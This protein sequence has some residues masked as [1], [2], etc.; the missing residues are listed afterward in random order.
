MPMPGGESWRDSSHEREIRAM[1]IPTPQDA[2]AKWAQNLAGAT[3]RIQKGVQSVTSS[4]G[5]AAARQKAV[6]LAQVQAK[7][8]K[9]AANTGKVSTA[10]WQQATISK[11]IPRIAQGAQASQPKMEAFMGRFLPHMASVVGSLPPRGGLEANI[12]RMVATVRGAATFK[13]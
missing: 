11:G 5:A 3:D 7:A 2:A 4:P 12:Q 6:Y 9:W 10:D 13:G 8:D 1:A